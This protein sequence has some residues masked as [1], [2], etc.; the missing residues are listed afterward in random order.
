MT[1]QLAQASNF[2]PKGIIAMPETYLQS[3]TDRLA[4]EVV[5]AAYLR[6]IRPRRGA[7]S[8]PSTTRAG[9]PV[10]RPL[11]RPGSRRRGR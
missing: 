4:T 7:G 9:A 11:A 8:R 1:P 5:V 3:P 6:E 10:D 2:H